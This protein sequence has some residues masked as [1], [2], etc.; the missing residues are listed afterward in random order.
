MEISRMGTSKDLGV[1]VDTNILLYVYDRL[2]PFW[3]VIYFLDFKPRFFVHKLV[4]HELS[5]L[6]ARHKNSRVMQSR[7][8][9]A[10]QYLEVYKSYWEE[11]DCCSWMDTDSAILETAK[12]FNFLIFTNDKVLKNRALKGG[13]EIIFLMD[14]GK[15]IK[16]FSPI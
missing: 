12:K 7:I 10:R 5:T 4:F 13:I 1:L 16:S 9:L 6:E 8:R 2:D 11:I 3:K 14:K 15:I